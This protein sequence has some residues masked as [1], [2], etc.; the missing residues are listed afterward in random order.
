MHKK[1][2]ISELHDVVQAWYCSFSKN[3]IESLEKQPK[4]DLSRAFY[5]R[6]TRKES[7]VKVK[8]SGLSFP[9]N[10]FRVTMNSDEHATL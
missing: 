3:E 2:G 1:P 10:Q 6:W 4:E 5:R 9:L 8:G 7:F